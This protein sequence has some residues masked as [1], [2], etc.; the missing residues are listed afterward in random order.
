MFAL[1]LLFIGSSAL[2]ESLLKSSTVLG[3]PFVSPYSLGSVPPLCLLWCSFRGNWAQGPQ[4]EAHSTDRQGWRGGEVGASAE[5]GCWGWRQWDR[6]HSH[7]HALNIHAWTCTLVWIHALTHIFPTDHQLSVAIAPT[8][9]SHHSSTS[10]WCINDK[11][12]LW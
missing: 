7:W 3:S 6:A 1:A 5:G 4:S 10:S 2:C 9:L 11:M 8:V 12:P